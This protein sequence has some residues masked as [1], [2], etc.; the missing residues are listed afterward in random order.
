MNF[1]ENCPDYCHKGQPYALYNVSLKP[2]NILC[3]LHTLSSCSLSNHCC[4]REITQINDLNSNLRF[5]PLKSCVPILKIQH[6]AC[7]SPLSSNLLSSSEI[8]LK[9]QNATSVVPNPLHTLF[10]YSSYPQIVHAFAGSLATGF[11]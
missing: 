8:R 11:L 2:I 10:P 7:F 1:N 4:E 6:R 5:C 9:V 3:S